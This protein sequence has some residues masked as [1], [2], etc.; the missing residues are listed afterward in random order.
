MEF[1]AGVGDAKAKHQHRR[2]AAAGLQVEEGTPTGAEN[3]QVLPVVWRCPK[4]LA[5]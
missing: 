4:G 1:T 5:A 3:A 2:L